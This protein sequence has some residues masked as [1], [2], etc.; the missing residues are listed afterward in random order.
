TLSDSRLNSKISPHPA[1]KEEHILSSDELSDSSESENTNNT[2]ESDSDKSSEASSSE[3]LSEIIDLNEF[4]NLGKQKGKGTQLKKLE[5][6]QEEKGNEEVV[7]TLKDLI[8]QIATINSNFERIKKMS[9]KEAQ[10]H[11]DKM[12]NIDI[13]SQNLKETKSHETPQE[14]L[15]EI[16]QWYDQQTDETQRTYN[17]D[18][19]NEETQYIE[20]TDNALN[21]R[22]EQYIN[23]K[24]PYR[25]AVMVK[26]TAIANTTED[27]KFQEEQDKVIGQVL[28]QWDRNDPTRTLPITGEP[29]TK[30]GD[31][32][33]YNIQ[34]LKLLPPLSKPAKKSNWSFVPR[35]DY[36][37]SPKKEPLLKTVVK[38]NAA[39]QTTNAG[40]TP[41]A[42]PKNN[43]YGYNT[44][45]I[46]NLEQS[47]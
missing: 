10:T 22:P 21:I 24:E 41:P 6:L 45:E 23:L 30:G 25:R 1:K 15:F 4:E 31:V 38:D 34:A 32:T 35:W 20:N 8:D 7:K 5:R 40:G 14:K 46:M 26:L 39:K 33:I 47:Y 16:I 12:K 36:N 28:E 13:L 9:D 43:Q 37:D 44:D 42:K 19:E 27:K 3:I 17:K 11:V 29:F 2:E 18:L